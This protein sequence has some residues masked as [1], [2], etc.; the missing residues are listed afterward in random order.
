[1]VIPIPGG[2][3]GA[4][5]DG[6]IPDQLDNRRKMLKNCIFAML[7][8]AGGK[9]VAGLL[10]GD[11]SRVFS[12]SLNLVLNIV[13]G[14]FLLNDDA[15]F[16]PIYTFMMDTCFQACAEQCRGGLSCLMTWILCN[17]LTVVLDILLNNQLATI[18]KGLSVIGSVGAS[19]PV[20]TF[21][22]TLYL[23]STALALAAQ[24]A[25]AWCGWKVHQECQANGIGGSVP[26]A[27]ADEQHQTGGGG[28]R[29]GGGWGSGNTAAPSSQQE[30][31]NNATSAGSRPPQGFQAFSGGGQRL[32]SG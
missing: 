2:A 18:F 4:R 32:G 27:W 11:M 14:I 29:L 22:M 10:I 26:G 1:M 6:P 28:N 13:I 24:S 12:S 25:G 23:L 30:M 8:A 9:L 15:Q 20:F 21:A 17:V 3:M 16:R 5:L 31:S 7:A 19:Q